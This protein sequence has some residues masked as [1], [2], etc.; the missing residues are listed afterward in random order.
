M[1]IKDRLDAQVLAAAAL[2]TEG[3]AAM[4]T[5]GAD[6]LHIAEDFRPD[7]GS[8]TRTALTLLSQ[9]QVVSLDTQISVGDNRAFVNNM[10]RLRRLAAELLEYT[11]GDT[12]QAPPLVAA[13]APGDARPPRV[14]EVDPGGNPILA[15]S[16]EPQPDGEKLYG[17]SLAHKELHFI[18]WALSIADAAMAHDLNMLASSVQVCLQMRHTDEASLNSLV[19]K[20]NAAHSQAQVDDGE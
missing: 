19:E 6:A 3:F 14:L 18:Y 4:G 11:A 2:F 5:V 9:T 1:E 12:V 15:P 20:F 17:L 13:P 16:L 10:H 7:R 8:V